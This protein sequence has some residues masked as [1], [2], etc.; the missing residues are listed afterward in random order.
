V[1]DLNFV[2]FLQQNFNYL[3]SIPGVFVIY[4]PLS[5]DLHE[6]G[7]PGGDAIVVEK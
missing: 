2:I 3:Q 6:A 4:P 7:M 5:L 1:E